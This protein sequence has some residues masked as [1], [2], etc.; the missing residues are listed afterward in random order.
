MI[1]QSFFR[2]MEFLLR[3][4]LTMTVKHQGPSGWKKNSVGK[5]YLFNQIQGIISASEGT[6][7]YTPRQF[8]PVLVRRPTQKK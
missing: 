8:M 5:A 7:G 6:I 3:R 2:K 1:V 4:V